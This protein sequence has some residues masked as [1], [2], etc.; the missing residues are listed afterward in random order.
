VTGGLHK[1]RLDAAARDETCHQLMTV[2]GR[3]P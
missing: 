2:P 3:A 1:K